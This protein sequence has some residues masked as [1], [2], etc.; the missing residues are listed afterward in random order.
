MRST[1]EIVWYMAAVLVLGTVCDSWAALAEVRTVFEATLNE[2]VQTRDQKLA[3]YRGIYLEKLTA[4]EAAVK[5]RS[6]FVAAGVVRRERTRF[7]KEQVLDRETLA[8]T[9]PEL[10]KLQDAYLKAVDSIPVSEARRVLILAQQYAS[11][12]DRLR[13]KLAKEEGLEAAARV[14]EERRALESRKEV[15]AAQFI[16]ADSWASSR[17]NQQARLTQEGH[18]SAPAPG[19]AAHNG[20]D[21]AKE[22]AVLERRLDEKKRSEDAAS[23]D[24]LG[25]AASQDAAKEDNAVALRSRKSAQQGEQFDKLAVPPI[26]AIRPGIAPMAEWDAQLFENEESGL[27]NEVDWAAGLNSALTHA[28][29]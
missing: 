27:K 29:D 13:E 4:V 12:L 9:P 20:A 14:E 5:E 21:A 23:K 16:L 2:I 1:R 6:D 18:A 15:T 19:A 10:R 26:N 3:G 24:A 11:A 7:D 25:K 17:K 28:L 8:Q 22:E